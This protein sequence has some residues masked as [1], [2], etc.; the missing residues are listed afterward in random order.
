VT[1]A[2]DDAPCLLEA[3]RDLPLVVD[4]D[5]TLILSD[6]LLESMMLALGRHPVRLFCLLPDALASRAR[7]KRR[8]LA[9]AIPDV[10]TLP[11]DQRLLRLLR[12]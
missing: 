5:G 4:L 6:T 10:S 3:D 1:V 7:F 12:Q 11:Y 9:L 2:S 8:V